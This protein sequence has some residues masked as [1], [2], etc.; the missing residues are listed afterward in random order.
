MTRPRT[1]EEAIALLARETRWCRGAVPHEL[2]GEVVPPGFRHIAE[3]CF[4]LRCESGYGYL[5]RPGEGITIER[6]EGADLD[7]ELL[8]LRGTVHS[9]IACLNGFLPVHASAVAH[10]GRVIAFTGPA[11]AGKSTLVAG[12]GRT[13]LPM[14]CDDTLLIDLADPARLICMPGHK[15]LKL[16]PDALL[17]TGAQAEQPVGADTGKHYAQPLG[18]DMRQPLPLDTLVF[19]AEGPELAWE[20]I[21]GAD[22]FARMDDDH[23]TQQIYLD[24]ARPTRA[25]LFAMRARIAANVTMARLVRPR[26]PAG[27]AASVQLV[28][29]RLREQ[30]RVE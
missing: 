23:H 3:G 25:A 5:Y 7:E 18:G 11:G 26:S 20:P 24:A 8:W 16:L 22:R 15:R 9:A 17:L 14:F 27:F 10:G 12:L 30:E 1:P 4:L 21:L 13:G 28:A 29:A 2:A 19:L 6:P